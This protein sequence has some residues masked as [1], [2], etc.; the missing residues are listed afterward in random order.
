MKRYM[1]MRLERGEDFLEDVV[2]EAAVAIAEI[3]FD[4]DLSEVY[5]A[6]GRAAKRADVRWRR[7]AM[8][9]GIIEDRREGNEDKGAGHMFIAERLKCGDRQG[10]QVDAIMALER[11][12][13]VDDEMLAL[14]IDGMSVVEMAR[15]LRITLGASLQRRR[16]LAGRATKGSVS[17]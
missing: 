2:S 9:V 7:E 10:A 14:L 15:E 6:I 11:T 16:R 3:G 1:P 8:E 4:A 17:V 12:I 5:R 13:G